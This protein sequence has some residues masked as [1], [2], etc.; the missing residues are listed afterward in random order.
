MRFLMLVHEEPGHDA[1]PPP[2][3]LI[4]AVESL[5][6]DTSLGRWLDDGGLAPVAEALW[7]RTEDGRAAVLDGP[8]A[9]SKEVIGGFFVVE[10]ASRDDMT[11]WVEQFIGLHARHW[12]EL[13]Y[14]AQVRQ[15]AGAEA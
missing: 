14:T 15:I 12:P 7:V 1:G 13:A 6:A 2:A 10:A 8:F 4:D 11:R 9:E 5:R 3:S